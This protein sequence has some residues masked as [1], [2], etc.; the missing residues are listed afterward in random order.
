VLCAAFALGNAVSKAG[1]PTFVRLDADADSC[2][3]AA[4]AANRTYVG[5]V[6]Y[7]Y[8]PFGCY[9]HTFTDRV[10]HNVYT[11]SIEAETYAQPLC[12]GAAGK[13]THARAEARTGRRMN[14]PSAPTH[15]HS[16]THTQLSR[17]THARAHTHAH[18]RTYCEHRQPG[19]I[20]AIAR[21]TD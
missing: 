10:Y 21:R 20:P 11:G 1:P 17:C 9:W 14:I 2:K 4:T 12:A 19:R 3:I 5:I 7:S 18:T 13:P 8:Y 6:A 15:E 16:N